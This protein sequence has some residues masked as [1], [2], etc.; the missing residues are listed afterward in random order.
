MRTTLT[1]DP[2]VQ[3]LLEGEVRRTNRSFKAVVNDAIRSGLT[4]RGSSGGKVHLLVSD[5]ALRPGYVGES[6]NALADEIEDEVSLA[7]AAR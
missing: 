4:R 3:Q 5:S 2:D 7:S 1:L 6:F